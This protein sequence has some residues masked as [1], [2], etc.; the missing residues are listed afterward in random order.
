MTKESK[1]QNI[2]SQLNHDFASYKKSHVQTLDNLDQ[3][4]HTSNKSELKS[5]Q[6][7]YE[8]ELLPKKRN[9]DNI[10][11]NNDEIT[12]IALDI[13]DANRKISSMNIS[14]THLQTKLELE[15]DFVF[16][17]EKSRKACKTELENLKKQNV[18]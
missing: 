10:I 13:K 18:N 5:I 1:L 8:E 4:L 14:L 15:E 7:E 17:L 11:K 12:E 2:Q 16:S 3:K 9:L 6:N